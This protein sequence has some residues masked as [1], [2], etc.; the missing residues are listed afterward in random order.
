MYFEGTGYVPGV[1]KCHINW[2][3]MSGRFLPEASTWYKDMEKITGVEPR[4]AT[5]EDLQ[6]IFKCNGVWSKDCNSKGLQFP[7]KCTYP[8]CNLCTKNHPGKYL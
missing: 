1:C 3:F 7:L 2:A 6:R 4:N 5:F 8:P